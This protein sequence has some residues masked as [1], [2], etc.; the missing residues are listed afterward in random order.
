MPKRNEDEDGLK[1]RMVA[2]KQSYSDWK[3]PADGFRK[4]L[5]GD[6]SQLMEQNK[7]VPAVLESR[8]K[9]LLR[10]VLKV[11]RYPI[12]EV[13]DLQDFVG[14]RLVFLLN[15]EVTKA[16]KLIRETFDNH[17]LINKGEEL[18]FNEFGYR[19]IHIIARLPKDWLRVPKYSRF[20]ALQFEIQLRTLSEHNYAVISSV[21][22]YHQA[23]TVPP[24]IQRSLL[25]LAAILEL[26]DLEVDRVA[27]EK[28]AYSAIALKDPRDD[29]RLNVD[30]ISRILEGE[31][32][33]EH[34]KVDDQYVE[35]FDELTRKGIN[36]TGQLLGLIKEFR[37]AA[38]ALNRAAARSLVNGDDPS[39]TG[40]LEKAR[41]G[42]FYSQV[43]LVWNMLILKNRPSGSA[44]IL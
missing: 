17:R 39:L 21:F 22:Q 5:E 20:G 29:V 10:S 24:T 6:L 16:V 36:T 37:G 15:E 23:G 19:A 18:K 41:Q 42:V 3:E 12:R 26:V 25:R 30:L 2:F 7:L 1:E 43:G 44:D 28:L 11:E 35:L 38:M 34:R 13:A 32:P 9:S 27:R 31:L 14:L 4:D 40:D 8:L 33:K